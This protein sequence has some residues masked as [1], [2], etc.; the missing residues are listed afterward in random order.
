MYSTK[1]GSASPVSPSGVRCSGSPPPCTPNINNRINKELNTI[2]GMESPSYG[3]KPSGISGIHRQPVSSDGSGTVINGHCRSVQRLKER[4]PGGDSNASPCSSARSFESRKTKEASA[5]RLRNSYSDYPVKL[6]DNAMRTKS[7]SRLGQQKHPSG[8]LSQNSTPQA[9]LATPRRSMDEVSET[10]ST[11]TTYLRTPRTLSRSQEKPP[12]NSSDKSLNKQAVSRRSLN[13]ED[14]ENDSFLLS[15][16]DGV[17]FSADNPD[18]GFLFL[19]MARS[20][21][22]SGEDPHKAR[23]Y[24]L[25]AAEFFEKLT[26]ADVTLELV[27]SLHLL[28]ATCC[29]LGQ[30]EEAVPILKKSL[31]IYKSEVDS[32]NALAAF[33]GYM[34]LGDTYSLSGQ[35]EDALNS[36]DAGLEIQKQVLGTMDPQVAE[37][38]QYIA[39]AHLQAMQFSEAEELCAEALSIHSEHSTKGTLKEASGRRLMALILAGKGDHDGALENLLLARVALQAHRK[40]I[41]VAFVDCSIGDSY[42][43]LGRYEDA[44]LAYHKALAVF[45][46]AHGEGH[47]RVASVYVNLA[48][49]HLR[50]GRFRE[51]K[52]HCENA[53][54]IYGRHRAGHSSDEI[55]TGLTEI[56]GLFESMGEYNQAICLLQKALEILENTPGQQSAVGGIEAQMGVLFQL[57]GKYEEAYMFF[58]KAVSKLKFGN[59]KK[60]WPLG[61]LLNQ[62]GLACIGL[63]ALWDAAEIFEEARTIA[64]EV[65][66]PHHPDTLDIISN[67]AGAYDAMGRMDDA[68]TLLEVI[69]EV[70]EEGLGTVHPDIED[71]RQRLTELLK[72]TGRPYVRKMNTL[73]DLLSTKH[74]SRFQGHSTP[75][76]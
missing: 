39:E 18:V 5:S 36:Y 61:M 67:L 41:E 3:Q 75:V 14:E 48:D 37:T 47:T 29:K 49:L 73:Q 51:A 59:N 20:L 15:E 60:S 32:E 11:D 23:H 28:A 43:A 58:K 33:A 52:N 35:Y 42:L 72:E 6:P 17:H 64:E 27:V 44:I 76:Q 8:R 62:M 50:T 26:A 13:K 9:L 4:L 57:I 68:I 54:I 22:I 2:L 30:Y 38:C 19:K 10:G 71:E 46:L 45:K 63:N 55:S 70:K 40:E 56:A 25:Q 7:N 65:C 34:Q 16:N 74:S 12:R 1:G 53:L 69:V 66:G 21:H 31:T 24:A